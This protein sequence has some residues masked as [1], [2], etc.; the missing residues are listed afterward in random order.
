MSHSDTVKV[1]N[2]VPAHLLRKRKR[3][4]EAQR[5]FHTLN[6][7]RRS[8]EP[9]R[10]TSDKLPWQTIHRPRQGGFGVNSADEGAVLM[11]E[12]VEGVDVHYEETNDGS[13]I[14]K[15]TVCGHFHGGQAMNDNNF[16]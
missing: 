6:K 10:I 3:A 8:D 11:L 1:K 15:F 5:V 12:E 2:T 7:K 9:V 13:R 4:V 14:A 16:I